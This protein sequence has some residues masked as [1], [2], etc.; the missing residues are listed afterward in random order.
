M[1][2]FQSENS[3]NQDEFNKRLEN[4]NPDDMLTLIYTS[5]T[6]RKPHPKG[7]IHNDRSFMNGIFPSY[8]RFPEV[9]L[10]QSHLRYSLWVMS[11]KGCGPRLYDCRCSDCLL[12]WSETVH[13]CYGVCQTSLYDKCTENM[14]EGLRHN[15]WRSKNSFTFKA[16]TLQLR[17]RRCAV[18]GEYVMQSTGIVRKLDSLGRITL[19]MELLRVKVSTSVRENL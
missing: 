7:A 13:R 18:R 14:G 5:G 16:K 15:T 3:N 2:W 11:L 6:N 1:T 12:S 19:P 10:K 17:S 8:M 4:V 9:E